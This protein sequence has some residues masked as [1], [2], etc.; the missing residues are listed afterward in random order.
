M[1]LANASL[2]LSTATFGL[3]LGLAQN[4]QAASYLV[5]NVNA[6][7]SG[8]GTNSPYNIVN[9]VNG[10]GLP[11]NTPSLTGNHASS[12]NTNSWRS[13]LGFLAA[14]KPI[15]ITF[16]F[17]V[18]RNLTGLSFWNATDGSPDNSQLFGVKDVTFQYLSGATWTALTPLSPWTGAFT[19]G[20]ASPQL[21]DFSQ[22]T[23]TQVRFNIAS[24]FGG[25]RVAINEVQFKA[26]PEPSASLALLALG[27]AGVGL[28]KRA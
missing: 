10:Q 13:A 14:P 9:I 20:L 26:V 11:G 28:R 19:Q 3:M 18:A 1:K 6:S 17:G 8:I 5:P 25:Q 15:Q 27:L 2:A 4:A 24:N 21:V 22:V 7:V 12:T 23:T 16:N